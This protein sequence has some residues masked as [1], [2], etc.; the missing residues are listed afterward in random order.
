MENKPLDNVF[1]APGWDKIKE[2]YE[3]LIEKPGFRIEKI[4]SSGH[5]SP[6]E[7]WYDQN[8]NETVILLKGHAVIE[9]EKDRRVEMKTGD[10]LT[11]YAHEL[12]KVVFTSVDPECVWVAVFWN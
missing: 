2:Y 8:E 9:F 1:D 7:G 10:V 11:I 3:T 4:M 6:A 12:H 5:T